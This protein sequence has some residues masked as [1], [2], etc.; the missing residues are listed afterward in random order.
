MK[1]SRFSL[2]TDIETKEVTFVCHFKLEDVVYHSTMNSFH[3]IELDDM[4]CKIQ[5]DNLDHFK[6]MCQVH[7]VSFRFVK[8]FI[9]EAIEIACIRGWDVGI[10]HKNS[11]WLR[12][13]H[14]IQRLERQTI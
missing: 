14:T 1:D 3:F 7:G 2:H 5:I 10:E 13:P 6:T 11:S 12:L 9:Q 4:T 8:E